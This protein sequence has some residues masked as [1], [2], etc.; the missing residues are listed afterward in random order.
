MDSLN[1]IDVVSQIQTISLGF[2]WHETNWIALG[3]SLKSRAS[4]QFPALLAQLIYYGNKPFIGQNI[5]LDTR[6][7]GIF[8]QEYYVQL[9]FQGKSIPTWNWGI[10]F[11]ILDG[12]TGLSTGQN[13]ASLFTNPVN[14]SL[15]GRLNYRVNVSSITSR[16]PFSNIG[17]AIDIGIQYQNEK[18]SFAGAIADLGM[19]KWNESRQ[20]S[21]D[22][23]I[24]FN[25]LALLNAG[26]S[27]DA[28][29]NIWID[30]LKKEWEPEWKNRT[31][32]GFLP[33]KLFLNSSYAIAKKSHFSA[34]IFFE[35]FSGIITA[36]AGFGFH[37][38]IASFMDIGINVRFNALQQYQLGNQVGLKVGKLRIFASLDNWISLMHLSD[39][40]R[41]IGGMMGLNYVMNANNYTK[42]NTRS[43]MNEKKFFRK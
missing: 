28:D 18:V 9:G 14:Y 8:Y 15:S 42:G 11:K 7:E 29:F 1:R 37:Q 35:H 19:I 2:K 5:D 22:K 39:T 4:I 21:I 41:G 43:R 16:R 10:K 17:A 24:S 31:F 38:Q 25:G 23:N 34:F 33:L 32:T 3:H 12:I 20:L 36:K 40:F 13:E 30:T 26:Q 6:F 27:I